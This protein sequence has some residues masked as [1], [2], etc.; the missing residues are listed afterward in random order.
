MLISYFRIIKEFDSEEVSENNKRI[1]IELN[2]N[3]QFIQ[4]ASVEC[5]Q[6]GGNFS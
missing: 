2:S 5:S 3:D 4:S 6:H 1:I